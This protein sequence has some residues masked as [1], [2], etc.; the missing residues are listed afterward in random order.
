MTGLFVFKLIN[1]KNIQEIYDGSKFKKRGN[2]LFN[3]YNFGDI[4]NS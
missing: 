3:Y 4:F 1:F 2:Y